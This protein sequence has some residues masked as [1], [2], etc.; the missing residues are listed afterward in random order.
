MR[1]RGSADSHLLPA[2]DRLILDQLTSFF[3]NTP[4]MDKVVQTVPQASLE[5]T[6]TVCGYAG[7]DTRVV[8][9][10]AQELPGH[11]T[12]V[13]G[14]EVGEDFITYTYSSDEWGEFECTMVIDG[15]T[16]VPAQLAASP[17]VAKVK[18]WWLNLPD[19]ASEFEILDANGDGNITLADLQ[20]HAA[21]PDATLS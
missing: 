4:P 14:W 9:K 1:R 8:W 11:F 20:A 19:I 6:Y 21:G 17:T 15:D 12:K 7:T 13:V 18:G 3:I 5:L 16:P 10:G 2:C